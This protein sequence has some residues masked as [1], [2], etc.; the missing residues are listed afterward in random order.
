MGKHNVKKILL[1]IQCI[2][3]TKV[4]NNSRILKKIVTKFQEN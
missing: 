2:L 1:K 4:Y 3:C